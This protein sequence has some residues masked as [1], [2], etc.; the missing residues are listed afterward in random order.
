MTING[1]GINRINGPGKPNGAPRNVSNSKSSGS[2]FADSLR[3][4]AQTQA[5]PATEMTERAEKI[6]ELKAKV[7]SGTY[8]P[9]MKEV[10]QKLL[11]FMS[12]DA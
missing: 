6:Q 10:A 4:A 1:D 8:E 2:S 3:K 7:Q 11:K 9:D 12:K 5:P